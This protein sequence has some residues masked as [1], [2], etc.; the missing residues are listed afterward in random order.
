MSSGPSALGIA[1]DTS[2]TYF[3]MIGM[4][5]KGFNNKINNIYA[6]TKHYRAKTDVPTYF[7]NWVDQVNN[8][9][10]IYQNKRYIHVNP[11]DNYI[12]KSW[13]KNSNYEVMNIL[14]FNRMINNT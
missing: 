5:L 12:P 7:T 3:Y 1:S 4:D 2:A 13:R 8:I 14:E 6:G 10:Q 9:M 11:L